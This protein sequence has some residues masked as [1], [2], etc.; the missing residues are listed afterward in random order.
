MRPIEIE[1]V[2]S[3][4]T[5]FWKLLRLSIMS[6]PKMFFSQLRFLKLSLSSWDLHWDNVNKSRQLSLFDTIE[7]NQDYPDFVKIYRDILTLSR[8]F[9]GSSGSKIWKNWEIL[10]EKN[11]KI[12]SLLME[13]ETNCQD[14]PTISCLDRFL[15]LDQDFW[16]WSVVSRQNRDFS[17]VKIKF[18]KVSRFYRS[19]RQASWK[20]LYWD[21]WS[22]HDRDKSRPLTLNKTQK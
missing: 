14:W 21:S 12:N 18:L 22:R 8:L 10:I 17:I 11:D 1:I 4:K 20:C 9:W 19:L 2:I 16:D 5:N 6:R 15:D 3:V 7:I 13:I